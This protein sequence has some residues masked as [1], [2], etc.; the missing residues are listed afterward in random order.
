MSGRRLQGELRQHAILT[1]DRHHCSR[2]NAALPSA[3]LAGL[4][5]PR[6]VVLHY[7]ANVVPVAI[8][9]FDG[10]LEEAERIHPDA[11]GGPTWQ[12]CQ[13]TA[14][15]LDEAKP[16]RSEFCIHLSILRLGSSRS[17]GRRGAR[18]GPRSA[19]A[20]SSPA[21]GSARRPPPSSSRAEVGRTSAGCLRRTRVGRRRATR[22]RGVALQQQLDRRLE[23]EVGGLA[24]RVGDGGE[25]C[26]Y[27]APAAGSASRPGRTASP[28]PVARGVVAARAGDASR[29]RPCT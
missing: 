27:A 22:R 16:A 4:K 13:L 12:R 10:E 18:P 19:I 3:S 21:S 29:G 8:C 20:A 5:G 15:P 6:L 17:R 11:C 28:A 14:K 2:P 23:A 1:G 26:V 7:F 24:G 25:E 9:T